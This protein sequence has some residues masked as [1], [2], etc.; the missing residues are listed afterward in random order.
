M[1]PVKST[2]SDAIYHWCAEDVNG[3]GKQCEI[4]RATATHEGIIMIHYINRNPN[5][6]R[7]KFYDWM[8]R[9][10]KAKTYYS[11]YRTDYVLN[12]YTY[13]EL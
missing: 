2:R 8:E 7:E 4:V 9:V 10:S 5:D 6:F 11:Y 1:T 3:Q 13:F 12:K